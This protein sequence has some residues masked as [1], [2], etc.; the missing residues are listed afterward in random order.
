MIKVLIAEDV[1]MVRGALVALLR[2]ESDIEVVAEVADGDDILPA[3]RATRP[4]VAVID[5]DL[6]GKD[7]LTAAGELHE[8]LPETAAR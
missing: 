5:I 3:A 1:H 8:Q 4:D 7:G 6:P 2:L